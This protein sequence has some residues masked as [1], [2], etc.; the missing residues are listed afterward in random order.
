MLFKSNSMGK[1]PI[2]K[3]VQKS[4]NKQ[5]Q[6]TLTKSLQHT[7]NRNLMSSRNQKAMTRQMQKAFSANIN[8]VSKNLNQPTDLSGSVTPGYTYQPSEMETPL[9]P[10]PPS[11]NAAFLNHPTVT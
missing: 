6:R 3:N 7:M 2:P 4:L 8:Q 1:M 9:H 5:M 10:H 11:A